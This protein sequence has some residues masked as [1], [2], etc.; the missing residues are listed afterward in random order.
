MNYINFKLC[1]PIQENCTFTYLKQIAK[2]YLPTRSEHKKW[3]W[4]VTN[5]CVIW[6]RSRKAHLM[7]S[8]WNQ[9]QPAVKTVNKKTKH[10]CT[11]TYVDTRA[12]AHT[13][14]Q[15]QY[16]FFTEQG[17]FN[18][19]GKSVPPTFFINFLLDGSNMQTY[20]GTESREVWQCK[21]KTY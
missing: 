3:I 9:N 2:F 19:Y 16:Y 21:Y 14:T 5:Y 11:Y 6:Y 1:S 12:R 15:K 7:L 13:H 17:I 4:T 20:F 18:H 8:M 10:T